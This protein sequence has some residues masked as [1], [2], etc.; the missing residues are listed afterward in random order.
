[1]ILLDTHVLVWCSLE[2]SRLG[3]RSTALIQRAWEEGE[4]AASAISFWEVALLVERGRLQ[5]DR[6]PEDWRRTWLRDGLRELP[7]D[8]AVAMAGARLA[9]L[10]SDP[11]D[12]WIAAATLALD[13]RLITAD[14]PLLSWL[15]P[16]TRQDAR[17]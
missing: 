4:V 10:H 3:P 5:L 7:L 17:Q 15:A 16:P 1:M 8:G 6:S 9:G 12:R 11:A 2:P 13:A 14:D